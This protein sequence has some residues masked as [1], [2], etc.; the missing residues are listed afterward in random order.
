MQRD[1]T[2][3]PYKGG[4]AVLERLSPELRAELE[5]HLTVF[6]EEEATVRGI[7]RDDERIEMQSLF[8]HRQVST[9]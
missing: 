2:R 4:N 8:S 3:G 1:D 5:P 6:F 9:R 7:S